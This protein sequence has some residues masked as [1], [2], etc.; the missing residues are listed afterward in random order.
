MQPAIPEGK[1]RP[2]LFGHF[3]VCGLSPSNAT[4]SAQLAAAGAAGGVVKTAPHI[5]DL[6][7]RVD[8]V[9]KAL[10]PQL[11]TVSD[12]PSCPWAPG[13]WRHHSIA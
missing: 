6:L 3:V 13:G 11:A 10:P 2:H 8:D 9:R 12:D 4:V 5:I 1:P 7:P